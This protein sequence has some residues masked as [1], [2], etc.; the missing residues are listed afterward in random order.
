LVQ[1]KPLSSFSP[2]PYSWDP[3]VILFL[4][5]FSTL[6]EHSLPG[7]FFV[8]SDGA[9]RQRHF[10]SPSHCAYQDEATDASSPR[11]SPAR[12]LATR[13][14]TAA[15]AVCRA[16]APSPVGS[17]HPAHHLWPCHQRQAPAPTAPAPTPLQPLALPHART[18]RA[19][20]SN[21]ARPC[22]EPASTRRARAADRPPRAQPS[23]PAPT[24]R[25]RQPRP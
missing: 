13:P 20:A 17:S 3:L 8:L 19:D 6:V 21:Q 18:R 4:H 23:A 7:H 24:S 22:P 14:T 16:V 11:H 9:I 12:L 2:Y 5:L 15:A 10:A 1:P 25:S